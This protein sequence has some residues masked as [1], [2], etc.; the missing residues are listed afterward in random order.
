VAKRPEVSIPVTPAAIFRRRVPAVM[1]VVV[2]LYAVLAAHVAGKATRLGGLER[3]TLSAEARYVPKRADIVDRNG[4]KLA[5]NIT[6]Y[7]LYANREKI[8]PRDA[9]ILAKRLAEALP[10]LDATDMT[11]RMTQH[12]KGRIILYRKR[13]TPADINRLRYHPGGFPGIEWD[14]VEQRNYPNESLAAHVLGWVGDDGVGSSGMEQA[15]DLDLRQHPGSPLALSIDRRVQFILQ[16]ELQQQINAYDAIGGAGLVMDVQ[17]GELLA[18]VSL[19]DFDP[20]KPKTL[21]DDTNNTLSPYRNQLTGGTYEMGSTMKIFTNAIAFE[22]GRVTMDSEF[23][24]T[25]STIL[26]AGHRISDT[27]HPAKAWIKVPAIFAIH[28]SNVGTVRMMESLRPFPADVTALQQHYLAKFGLLEKPFL[29]LGGIAAPQVPQPWGRTATATISFGH[30]INI[31]AIQLATGVAAMVNGGVHR[32]ATVLKGGNIGK[33]ARRIIRPE[34]SDAIRRLMALC[35]AHPKGTCGNAAAPGYVVGGKT[36]TS[37]KLNGRFYAR[38]K[39][40]SLFIGA[41]PIYDPR[42]IVFAMV[43]EPKPQGRNPYATGGVVA[44]PIVGKTIQRL[45]PLLGI[46]PVDE[47]APAIVERTRIPGFDVSPAQTAYAPAL[48][49]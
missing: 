10:K 47:Q 25:T 49:R 41:F 29:E 27:I 21:E 33:A 46:A 43:D 12:P 40:R 28:S 18:A 26:I 48:S 19:P 1:M 6:A 31:N 20:N 5:T 22:E 36:G 37:D 3:R 32:E 2:A 14:P 44:A 8:P 7:E 42:F 16:E 34:T 23:D 38:N 35:V 17:T 24:A 9:P 30:G 45:A 15:R 4:E 39:R 11:S 13:L